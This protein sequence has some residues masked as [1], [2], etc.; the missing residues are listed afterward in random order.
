VNIKLA[1]VQ[2]RFSVVIMGVE[3][4]VLKMDILMY[5]TVGVEVSDLLVVGN[6]KVMIEV[7]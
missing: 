2:K 3:V 1:Q 6:G 5:I 4:D 7:V